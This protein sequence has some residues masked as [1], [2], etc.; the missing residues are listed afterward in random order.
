[1]GKEGGSKLINAC[2]LNMN[3]YGEGKNNMERGR[4]EGESV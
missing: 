4:K 2:K 1:M 3:N